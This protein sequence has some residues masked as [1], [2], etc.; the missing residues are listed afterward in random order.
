LESGKEIDV[1]ANEIKDKSFLK[2]GRKK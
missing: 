1:S 2:I